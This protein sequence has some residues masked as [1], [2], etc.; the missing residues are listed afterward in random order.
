MNHRERIRAIIGGDPV[1]RC[2]FWL[3][4]PH[5]ELWPLL[6]RHFGTRT[7]AELRR[8]LQ[9]E[10]VLLSAEYQGNCYDGPEVAV[11]FDILNPPITPPLAECT[12]IAELNDF[13]WPDAGKLSI[14][15]VIAALQNA[16]DVYRCSGTWCPFFHVMVNLFGMENYLVKM[17][18][19]PELIHSATNRV[20]QFY[21]D[22]NERVFS[23]ADSL[24]D[25][26]FFGN[27]FGTQSDLIC[28]PEHFDEFMLPW[29][30]QF[31]AQG[32]RHG[33]QVIMHSCGSIYKVIGRLI[34]AGVDCLHP[35]Q[36]R[37]SG[38][39][40]ETLARDFKGRLAFMG[41]VDTQELMTH[42]SSEDVRAEVRRLK[43]MLGPQLIVSPSHE[44]LLRNVP[45]S[46]VQAMAE[47]ARE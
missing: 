16:G 37:A 46:N 21:Y 43:A 34:D 4:H 44:T 32:H 28:S 35:L 33:H 7:E 31:A 40:A 25:G 20:C 27:D 36:T 10:F 2:G 15:P 1:D 22:A 5:A 12:E 18:E 29:I 45:S 24:V 17:Y 3:G 23:V 9:D 14:A 11:F 38:M 30:R 13:P 39:D 26:F 19:Q 8:L 41:G 47:A 6:H 42:A